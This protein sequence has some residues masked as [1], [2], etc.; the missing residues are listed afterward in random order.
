MIGR[1]NQQKKLKE[2]LKVNKSSFLAVTG[3]RR[4]G[5]TYLID[6]FFSNDI[7]FRLTGIQHADLK[8]QL[9]N[10]ASKLSEKNNL[11]ENKFTNW[12]DA[13]L[14][15]KKYLTSLDKKTKKV[16]FLDELPWV[17][18]P[19][20]KFLQFLAHLWN[21]YLSKEK[22]FILVVCGSS[23]SW[24]T[25]KIINDKGGLH[26]RITEI[27]NLKPFNLTETKA[28]FEHLNFKL[29][30]HELVKYYMILGGIPYYLEQ[31]KRG[32]SST[33]AIERLCFFNDGKLKN[34]YQNLYK[35]LF[36]NAENHEAIVKVLANTKSGLTR[37][38]IIK[39]TKIKTGG[40]YN[41]TID[42]LLQS[43][44]IKE[45]IP[46]NRKKRGVIYKLNDEYSIF[47]HKFIKPNSNY[48]NGMWSQLAASQTY[49]IWSG[50]SF[51]LLCFNH[52]DSIKKALGIAAVFTKISSLRIEGNKYE[53]GF[54]IDLIIDRND[55]VINLCEIKYYAAS[56]KIDKKYA[57]ELTERKQRFIEHTKTKKQ[58]FTTFITNHPIF[59]N[60]YKRDVVAVNISLE[61]FI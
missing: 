21:D 10:F 42:D 59:E 18:T 32:E 12:Q 23:T 46:F 15:L 35:A 31:L 9:K 2:L 6:T 14:E 33:I 19:K 26:N 49:K 13:F 20:S 27:I 8:S 1:E 30:L 29:T 24:I 57:K 5:K 51:E 56:F 60:E 55:A 39:N 40:P 7:C 52:I 34:E 61:D 4:V 41:R 36:K 43:G 53:K 28:F 54:Q 17:V 58:V 50:Y 16:I 45:F 11:E 48:T 44:F 25:K 37:N 3:R 47:Y 38:E 22:H